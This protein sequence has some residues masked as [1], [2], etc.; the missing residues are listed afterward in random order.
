[1]L[2]SVPIAPDFFAPRGHALL[3]WLGMAGAL[4]NVRGTIFLVDPLLAVTRREGAEFVDSGDRL[5]LT[6]PIEAAGLPRV[7]AV[8]YTH[9]DAD[10]YGAATAALLEARLQPSFLAPPP[11]LRRLADLGVAQERL[12]LAAE[13]A[14]LHLGAAEV[15]RPG[16]AT[17]AAQPRGGAAAAAGAGQLTHKGEHEVRPYVESPARGAP[18]GRAHRRRAQLPLMM[19]STTIWRNSG[20]RLAK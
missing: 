10:H 9:G 17:V 14:V 18:G 13:G 11:V 16:R 1:M 5:L 8:L 19:R 7:D 4:F 12:L 20:E 15:Q 2:Q 3:T 6:L